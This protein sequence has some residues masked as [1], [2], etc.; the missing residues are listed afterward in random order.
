M[1]FKS[2]LWLLV[3]VCILVGVIRYL[4]RGGDARSSDGPVPPVEEIAGMTLE[5][6][7]LSI[8]LLRKETTWMIVNPVLARADAGQMDRILS[9]LEAVPRL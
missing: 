9:T 8:D 3:A 5:R 7:D 6:G 1:K 2:T 4:E